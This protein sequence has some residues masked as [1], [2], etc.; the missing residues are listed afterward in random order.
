MSWANHRFG[1]GLTSP[2]RRRLAVFFSRDLFSTFQVMIT[3]HCL[4][5]RFGATTAVDE[6]TFEVLPGVVTGLSGPND[7]GKSTTIRIITDLDVP[8]FGSALIGGKLFASF[9]LSLLSK[10]PPM[11]YSPTPL[12]GEPVERLGR[13]AQLRLRLRGRRACAR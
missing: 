7:S 4:T 8:M 6:L 12:H 10:H 13:P 3:A 2:Q 9:L 11:H 5:K 1:V